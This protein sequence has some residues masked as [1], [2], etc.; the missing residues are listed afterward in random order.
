MWFAHTNLNAVGLLKASSKNQ[1]HQ[2]TVFLGLVMKI[3]S[4]SSSTAAGR[5]HP[6]ANVYIKIMYK[7]DLYCSVP[8]THR[9]AL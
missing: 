6:R 2:E 8:S 3:T 5:E 1:E 4:S 7:H 9:I